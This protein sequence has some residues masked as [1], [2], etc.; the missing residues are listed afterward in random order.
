MLTK[1][2]KTLSATLIGAIALT[3]VSTAPARAG[4]NDAL[5]AFLFGA[6]VLAIIAHENDGRRATRTR[7]AVTDVPYKTGTGAGKACLRKR[8]SEEGW[9][10]YR[11]KNCVARYNSDVRKPAPKAR[12]AA[13]PREC[14]RQRWTDDGW[15]KF[16]SNTCLKRKGYAG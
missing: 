16:W 6:G 11:N 5:A 7:P 4:D 14:L 10:V 1:T 13:K 15:Q 9:V 3:G 8:W 12:K 2:K